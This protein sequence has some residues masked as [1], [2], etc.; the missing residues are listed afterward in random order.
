M[1]ELNNDAGGNSLGGSNAHTAFPWGAHYLPIPGTNDP[2]LT[3]FLKEI[4]VITGEEN[5]LPIFNDYYLCFE[6]KERLYIDHFWQD[7]LIPQAGIPND[8]KK[9]IEQFMAAMHG[10]RDQRGK[11]GKEAFTIPVDESS[12]DDAFLAYR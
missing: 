1:L 5:G 6:P 2:E 10:F 9:Q 4:N 3:K 8:D 12:Q 11:D 7:G